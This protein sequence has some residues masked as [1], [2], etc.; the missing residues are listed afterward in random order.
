[1]IPRSTASR[2]RIPMKG[3]Y[4]CIFF[5]LFSRWAKLVWIV[6]LRNKDLWFDNCYLYLVKFSLTF[7]WFDET[8]IFDKSGKINKSVRA[9]NV[10]R[11]FV[12]RILRELWLRWWSMD[13]SMEIVCLVIPVFGFRITGAAQCLYKRA[14]Q[15][16]GNHL[17]KCKWNKVT[18]PLRL[19]AHTSQS[20]I[21]KLEFYS[22]VPNF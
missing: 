22:K 4:R 19:K 15:S 11:S 17:A 21:N 7:N 18:D 20:W 5:L 16:Y 10:F 9:Q 1:M 12:C 8:L 2:L 6:C 13:I 3:Q 14:T